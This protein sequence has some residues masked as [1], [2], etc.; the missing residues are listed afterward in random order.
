MPISIPPIPSGTDP[1]LAEIIRKIA[2]EAA[3]INQPQN[4][5]VPS[6]TEFNEGK[7]FPDPTNSHLYFHFNG[8]RFRVT[9]AEA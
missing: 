6:N 1:S 4:Y 5:G 9:I 7:I 8:K 2:R 3:S